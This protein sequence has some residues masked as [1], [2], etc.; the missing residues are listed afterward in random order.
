MLS[1]K[2]SKV[3]HLRLDDFPSLEQ[4][5]Y[6]FPMTFPYDKFLDRIYHEQGSSQRFSCLPRTVFQSM[7]RK[8]MNNTGSHNT[9]WG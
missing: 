1:Q 5:L 2:I 6:H 9:S 8:I 7:Y 3:K 4:F